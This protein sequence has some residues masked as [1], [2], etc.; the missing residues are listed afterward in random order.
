[1]RFSIILFLVFFTTSCQHFL[2][3]LKP[4]SGV[5][6]KAFVHGVVKGVDVYC[7]KSIT[8]LSDVWQVM[9][10]LNDVTDIKYRTIKLNEDETKFEILIDKQK[11]EKRKTI[12]SPILLVSRQNPGLTISENQKSYLKFRI[13]RIR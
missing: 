2:E 4:Y 12:A 1:M 11:G 8:E 13:E 7:E 10:K 9:C 3:V 5:I 6:F